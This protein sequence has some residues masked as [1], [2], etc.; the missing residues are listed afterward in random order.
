MDACTSD[1]RVKAYPDGSGTAEAD[2]SPLGLSVQGCVRDTGAPLIRVKFVA[3]TTGR[4]SRTGIEPQTGF[5]KDT[6]CA[7]AEV[8]PARR[9]T[10]C[11]GGRLE[12]GAEWIEQSTVRTRG[13]PLAPNRR[14]CSSLNSPVVR[15]PSLLQPHTGYTPL[16]GWHEHQ[17]AG[18]VP[19]V[20]SPL[21]TLSPRLVD[22]SA[23]GSSGGAVDSRTKKK[24]PRRSD[25]QLAV[26]SAKR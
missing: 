18:A 6:N 2:F 21:L 8:R 16:Q 13:H 19:G 11:S 25:R 14:T 12:S 26:G 15:L 1:F 24:A 10:R 5:R 9:P 22:G 17:R 20:T 7:V 23:V 3:N 4:S